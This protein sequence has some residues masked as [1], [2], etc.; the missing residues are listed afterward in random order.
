[1]LQFDIALHRTRDNVAHKVRR[2]NHLF[3]TFG[4]VSDVAGVI[5][6]VKGSSPRMILKQICLRRI[7]VSLSPA[8]WGA[9]SGGSS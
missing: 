9:S 3:V 2:Y 6:N 7:S 5:P 1:M 8:S 4:L